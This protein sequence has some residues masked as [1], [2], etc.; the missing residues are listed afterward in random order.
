MDHSDDF[1]A[2]F[3][4]DC[5]RSFGEEVKQQLYMRYMGIPEVVT[6]RSPVNYDFGGRSVI[7]IGGGPC[8]VLLK[9]EN[10][11][12]GLVVDPGNYPSWVAACYDE[13]GIWQLQMEGE[14][15]TGNGVPGTVSEHWPNGFDLALIYNCLQHCSDPAR[16]IANARAAARELKMFEWVDIPP[17]EG[18][19]HELKAADLNGWA[20]QYGEVV[21]L[22]GEYGCT[23]RAWVLR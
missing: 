16:I 2:K 6:W 17:H 22:H 20:D 23:G 3:W 15:F 19:P 1:E 10:L 7:D 8:S 13:A 4:G 11:K 14:V 9:G 5:C 12:G 21:E 18:H